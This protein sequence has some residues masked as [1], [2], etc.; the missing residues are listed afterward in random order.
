MYKIQTPCFPTITN[1]QNRKDK[2][3][4][5]KIM[6]IIVKLQKW[7]SA[8]MKKSLLKSNAINLYKKIPV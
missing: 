5:L 4:Q 8:P 2:K 6:A 3:F 7:I 1:D